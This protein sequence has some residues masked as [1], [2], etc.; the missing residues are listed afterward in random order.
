MSSVR[1]R[2]ARPRLLP[3]LFIFIVALSFKV[4][5]SQTPSVSPGFGTCKTRYIKLTNGLPGAPFGASIGLGL[6]EVNATDASGVNVARNKSCS[7]RSSYLQPDA[8]YACSLAVDGVLTNV[9]SAGGFYTSGGGSSAEFLLIDLG[10]PTALRSMSVYSRC[11]GVCNYWLAG[12][13]IWALAED[14]STIAAFNMSAAPPGGGLQT[15]NLSSAQCPSV[16][17]S[18]SASL[19]ATTYSGRRV[20]GGTLISPR[21][22][23]QASTS[24]LSLT[25]WAIAASSMRSG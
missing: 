7:C 19:C 20:E 8:R 3:L 17:P 14:N 15:F 16:S 18:P 4:S 11:D 24:S 13:W 25:I 5:S 9:G 21:R 23:R 6:N 12:Q 10:T 2:N 1:A 22:L